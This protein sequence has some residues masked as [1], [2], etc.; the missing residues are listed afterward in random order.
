MNS[1]YISAICA[2]FLCL[3]TANAVPAIGGEMKS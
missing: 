1:K 2:G 3:G